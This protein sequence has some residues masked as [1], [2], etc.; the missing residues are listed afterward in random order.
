M[1]LEDKVLF[2]RFSKHILA[3]LLKLMALIS[4]SCLRTVV[5]THLFYSQLTLF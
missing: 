2:T 1:P 3:D 5:T 4:T